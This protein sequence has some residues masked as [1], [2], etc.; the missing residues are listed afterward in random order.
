M[1]NKDKNLTAEEKIK[2]INLVAISQTREELTTFIN[3]YL[4]KNQEE[5]VEPPVELPKQEKVEY[6]EELPKQN[7]PSVEAS[8]IEP[9]KE[10]M[11]EAQIEVPSAEENY[12]AVEASNIESKKEIMS[13]AQIEVP[14]LEENYNI[15]PTKIDI[16][17]INSPNI[18]D[19]KYR[20]LVEMDRQNHPRE[21]EKIKLEVPEEQIP[22]DTIRSTSP[23]YGL[24]EIVPPS[25]EPEKPKVLEKTI[26][27]PWASSGAKTVSPGELNLE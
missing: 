23:S 13:E 5:K 18:Y 19:Q 17:T 10:I 22:S 7:I 21:N 27:N 9:K 15:D 26:N 2:I 20:H 25:E 4:S 6:V 14:P 3:N 8:N 12:N 1:D 16:S 11:P 24:N